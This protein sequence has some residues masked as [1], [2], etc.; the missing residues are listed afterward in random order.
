MS[1]V[2]SFFNDAVDRSDLGI[3]IAVRAHVLCESGRNR[4]AAA[5]GLEAK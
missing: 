1:H 3:G 5:C 2:A 4:L